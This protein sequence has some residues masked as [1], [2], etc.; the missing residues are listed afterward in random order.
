M[1][2]SGAR[3]CASPESKTTDGNYAERIGDMDSGLA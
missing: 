3:V 1:S 2:H